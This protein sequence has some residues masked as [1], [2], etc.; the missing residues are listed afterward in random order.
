[1]R[2]IKRDGVCLGRLRVFVTAFP[3]MRNQNYPQISLAVSMNRQYYQFS[4]T[5]PTISTGNL[6]ATSRFNANATSC[7]K[8]NEPLRKCSYITFLKKYIFPY[9]PVN[10]T[11]GSGKCL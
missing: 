7:L 2:K 8:P 5:F 10:G 9:I 3:H 1:M 11:S 4:D 6:L